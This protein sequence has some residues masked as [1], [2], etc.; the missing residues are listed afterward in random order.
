MENFIALIQQNLSKN[1]FPNKK[2]S[3]GLETLYEAADDKGLSLNKVLD[4]L[5]ERGIDHRKTNEKIIFTP[6]KA[7]TPDFSGM[8]PDFLARAQAM[9]AHMSEE[10]LEQTRSMVTEQLAN[11]SPEER[12]QL[13]AQIKG[14][15]LG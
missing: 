3:F 1:G 10:E 11:M 12:E 6:L 15:G 7:T 14:M 2:V 9:M 8:D 5:K 13:F 4:V